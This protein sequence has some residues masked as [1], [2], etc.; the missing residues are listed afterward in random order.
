[1]RKQKPPTTHA[2]IVAKIGAADQV[3][4]PLTRRQLKEVAKDF[5][6]EV[7]DIPRGE[8]RCKL[9]KAITPLRDVRRKV[10]HALLTCEPH[11]EIIAYLSDCGIETSHSRLSDHYQKHVLPY[12]MDAYRSRAITSVFVQA[13]QQLGTRDS[14]LAEIM[15]TSLMLKLQPIV[16][17]L[18]PED[19]MRLPADQAIELLL[20]T[21][22]GLAA[23]QNQ[24]SMARLRALE[25]G[26]KEARLSSAEQ[27]ALDRA[28][29]EIGDVLRKH[30]DVWRLVEPILKPVA[31]TAVVPAKPAKSPKSARGA[32][33]NA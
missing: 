21:T 11:S 18:N 33:A 24:E 25:L 20:K 23:I 13:A 4:V 32:A 3:T 1:M 28:Y 10:N 12:I 27:H 30:G 26:L 14:S 2:E 22:R 16:E 19:L 8:P 31:S 7:Y 5:P 29:R 9:C 15:V 6:I 17:A